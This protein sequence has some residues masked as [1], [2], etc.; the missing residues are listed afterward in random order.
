MNR[1][2][3]QVS[4]IAPR[5]LRAL[6]PPPPGRP[7][8]A[9]TS[10]PAPVIRSPRPADSAST[11]RRS[12]VDS[13]V[14]HASPAPTTCSASSR[15]LLD[16]RVDRSSS[17]PTQTSLRT[18]TLR[19]WPMR[20]ARSVAWS[21]TAGFHQRSKWTTWLAA[22]RFSPVPPALSDSRKQRRARTV[23]SWKPAHHL[24]RAL[25][26]WC[27]RA[28]TAPRRRSRSG[29]VRLQQCRPNSANWV[30][31]SALSPSASTSSQHLLE[32][33]ELA[34]APGEPGAVA[35][36]KCAGWLHTCLSLVSAARTQPARAR[37]RRCVLDA[38]S[39][40][41]STDGL[42]QRG[43]LGGEVAADLHL[44][45]SRAGRR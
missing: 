34:R 12:S 4:P 8:T 7:A 36:A 5:L 43:L 9:A 31:H 33:V 37:C 2:D 28:G 26:W 24:R 10:V 6:I 3:H 21:S 18:C 20:N 13:S 25:A 45:A 19:R 35:R 41:S 29:Q 23:G 38:A 42:V 44:D 39:S 27:R 16:H 22:V 14:I 17:V 15:L 32:P 30:K 40:M 11:S 1:R